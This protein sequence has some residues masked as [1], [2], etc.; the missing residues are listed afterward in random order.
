METIKQDA[1]VISPRRQRKKFPEQ[2]REELRESILANGITHPPSFRRDVENGPL[3]LVAGHR[4]YIAM[5]DIIATGRQVRCGDFT[6][7]PGE[8][9]YTYLGV[10]DEDTAF[11]ME[12]DEN[13]KR[14]DITWQERAEAEAELMERRTK[15]NAEKGLPPPT[16]TAIAAEVVQRE[17]NPS[18]PIQGGHITQVATR[19]RLAEHLDDPEVAKAKT[20]ADAVKIVRKKQE[21]ARVQALAEKFDAE[22]GVDNPH[23]LLIGDFRVR[24][25]QVGT[26]TVDCI[27]TDPP[28]GIDANSFGEQSGTGHNYEDSKEYFDQLLNT[29]AEESYRVA[30][31]QAHAY[32]FCDPRRFADIQISFELAGW[33]VWPIPIIWDKGNGMLPR[34]EHAPRRTYECI[35]YALKGKKPVR[36]VKPDVIRVPPVRD[37]KHGAQKPVDLYVDL[38]SRSVV[39]GNTVLDCFAGS[40]TIFPAGN[41]CKVKAIGIELHEPNANICRTR[42]L[43]DEDTIPGLEALEV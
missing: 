5:A 27:L 3:I 9:P 10:V 32:I 2:Q 37:L 34:P 6:C 33:E 30:K 8:V 42:M 13:I 43:G 4:R 26:G 14:L 16:F 28:Y 17:A 18:T 25:K 15:Q 23:D 12:L 41:R 7:P 31:P 36:A 29:L 19:I 39:P 40:G 20:E 24:I 35:L 11:E 21:A 38:L 22:I 1:V